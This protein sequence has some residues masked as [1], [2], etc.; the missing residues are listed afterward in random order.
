MPR[1]LVH[2]ASGAILRYGYGDSLPTAR[3]GESMLVHEVFNLDPATHHV[4]VASGKVLEHAPVRPADSVLVKHGWSEA[5]R[6]WVGI[7]TDAAVAAELRAMRAELLSGS[8]WTQGADS[9]LS[10]AQKSAWAAY[11]S[12]LRNISDQAGFPSAVEWPTPPT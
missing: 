2:D 3:E 7:P 10:G 8:D 4:D 1:F 12:A 5:L 9:P 6:R 11:R